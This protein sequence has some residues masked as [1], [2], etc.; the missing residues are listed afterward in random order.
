MSPIIIE[1]GGGFGGGVGRAM[2]IIPHLYFFIF[3]FPLHTV[4]ILKRLL[5]Q[6]R[7]RLFVFASIKIET[8]NEVHDELSHQ[9][10][11]IRFKV[12]VKDR[13]NKNDFPELIVIET[14][15]KTFTPLTR[16]LYIS[17]QNFV[18]KS[19]GRLKKWST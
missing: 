11:K 2:T 18:F 9:E 7:Q 4:S 14:K 1:G 10:R 6:I 17:D 13:G 3:Y 16:V 12:N 15:H 8:D 19:T 5:T